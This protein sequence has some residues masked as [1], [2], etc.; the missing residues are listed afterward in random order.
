MHELGLA[1]TPWQAR[2]MIAH[3]H[4]A[5]HG[6]KVTSP[7]Y[8]VSRGEEEFVKFAP[9]SPYNDSAHPA[10]TVPSSSSSAPI[11]DESSEE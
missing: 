4:I 2:Q 9:S 7:S 6:K 5:I 3:G 10:L 1:K 11:R 8:H